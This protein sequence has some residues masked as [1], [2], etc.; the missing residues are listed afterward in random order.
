MITAYLKRDLEGDEAA[1]DPNTAGPD[2]CKEEMDLLGA[3][4]AKHGYPTRRF[5]DVDTEY[6]EVFFDVDVNTP[7]EPPET[8]AGGSP[9]GH[10]PLSRLQT[11]LAEAADGPYDLAHEL[12]YEVDTVGERAFC[13]DL[14]RFDELPVVE[15]RGWGFAA[16]WEEVAAREKRLRDEGNPAP[17]AALAAIGRGIARSAGSGEVPVGVFEPARLGEA[18]SDVLAGRL[19]SSRRRA[20]L[21]AHALNLRQA[22]PQQAARASGGPASAEPLT[23]RGE[24]L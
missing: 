8:D 17:N 9:N 14:Y 13:D 15:V 24:R 7:S 1:E 6:L 19:V 22:A 16:T 2:P 10:D 5:V 18:L 12:R 11:F 3:L 4:A 23:T 21:K 20:D